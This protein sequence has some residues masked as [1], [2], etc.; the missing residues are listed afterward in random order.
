MT[1]R[2]P[3]RLL[4]P[5]PRRIL[6]A[7]DELVVSGGFLRFERTGAVLRRQGHEVAVARLSDQSAP[8][9]PS[10][11]PVLTFAEA[12][13]SNWDAVMVP[14]AGFRDEVIAMFAMFRSERF[15]VRVQHFLNDQ[16]RRSA[17]K[18]VND[19]LSPHLVVINNLAWPPGSYSE[20]TADRFHVLL[21]AVDFE[22]FQRGA[23]L[24][25]PR[26]A[27]EWIIGGL[28]R[29]NPEPLIESLLL[30]P[31]GSKLRLFGPEPPELRRRYADLIDAGRIELTGILA[32]EALPEFYAGLDCVAMTELHAGWSNLVAEAMA[33]SVPVVC[34]S[35][36]TAAFA[37]DQETALVVDEPT[38]ARLASAIS[39]LREDAGLAGKLRAAAAKVI[40][41]YTWQDYAGRLLELVDGCEDELRRGGLS[42]RAA[43]A[44]PRSSS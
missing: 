44:E 43:F 15:G 39:A 27:D 10:P 33:S 11:L 4:K 5:R 29:K 24:R 7:C 37:F 14:G 3:E 42:A 9:R 13:A 22:R 23:H 25:E 28:A 1:T 36:G 34:T 18:R 32:E 31:R 6:V 40:S 26:R 30:L 12:R 2:G 8:A 19:H 21:G 41:Q 35:H 38:P 17:F 16:T 20:F